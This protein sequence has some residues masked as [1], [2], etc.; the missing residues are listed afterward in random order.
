M[1]L[2]S[3]DASYVFDGM[4]R[5]GKAAKAWT[6]GCGDRLSNLPDD[7][8]QHALGFLEAGEAVRT[9]VLS[10][11]WRHLWRPV[12]RLRVTDVEAFRS[13]EKL[14]GFLDQLFLLRDAGSVLDE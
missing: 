6:A 10:R 11:R 5:R 1:V 9:S 14:S 8:L 4:S 13:V 12:P 3:T 7:V 2:R